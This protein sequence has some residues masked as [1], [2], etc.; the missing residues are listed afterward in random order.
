MDKLVSFDI[1]D[2]IIKRKCHP[3]E[4]KLKTSRYIWLKYNN[5]LKDEYKDIYK[6]LKKRNKI[7]ETIGKENEKLGN[8]FEYKISDVFKKLCDEVFKEKVDISEFT[9]PEKG[10]AL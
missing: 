10:T 1:W 4:V 7:E 9:I 6:L 5:I 3:E 8:D 2:T